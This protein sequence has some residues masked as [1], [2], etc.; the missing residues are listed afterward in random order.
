MSDARVTVA[1][2]GGV[3][4]L[5]LS[6]PEK[7]NVFDLPQA[8]QLWAALEE[9]D[10]DA[11]VR[12][13]VVTG[14]GDYF[15]AGADVSLFLQIG[16]LE[17]SRLEKAAKLY[18]PLRA[19]EKPTI[20]MV[21]GHAVGMGVTMLPSFDLVY[22]ADHVTF[23][24]PFVKLGLVLEYGS[25]HTFARLIGAQR[26]KEL[27]MRATPLD[28]KTAAE[29][30]LVTRCFSAD[31]LKPETMK[32]ASEI[33]A[34]P[35]GAVAATKRLVDEGLSRSFEEA[36]AA[37]DEVLEGLYGSEENVKAVNAFLNR[38]KKG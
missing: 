12:A 16:T 7:K 22:A 26:T 37:E 4:V 20:A 15:T 21:Q 27:M 24:T 17:R 11:A 14:D 10:A 3:R 28:A 31:A 25:S 23:T 33:A 8:E 19:C 32:I 9:A 18:A 13:I 5:T 38:K 2:S 35:P 36:A 1:D 34:H 29:W 6:R 30:G